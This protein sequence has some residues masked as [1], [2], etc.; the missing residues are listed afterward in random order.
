MAGALFAQDG[1]MRHTLEV[2]GGGMFPVAGYLANEYSAGPSW[3]PGYEYRFVKA[4]GAE[5]GFTEAWLP[6]TSCD[7]FA[8]SHPAEIF[9]LVDYG[10]RGHMLLGAGR[11]ELSA[12]VGGGYIWYRYG[13]PY[14]N[15]SLFQY[16]AKAALAIGRG[17]RVRVGATLRA[18]RDLGRPI[19]QWLSLVGSVSIGLGGRL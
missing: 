3:R 16:S 19:Q 17:K 7:R 15:G 6:G 1:V 11:V 9:K 5:A 13:S 10:I 12:G 18:W 4:L 14:T 8:C 2:G